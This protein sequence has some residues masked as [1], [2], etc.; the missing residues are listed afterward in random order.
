[1]F[2]C[3]IAFYLNSKWRRR[4]RFVTKK[5]ICTAE[6][7]L[8]SILQIL[9][10]VLSTISVPTSDIYCSLE[11]VLITDDRTKRICADLQHFSC[12]ENANSVRTLV[13]RKQRILCFHGY[14]RELRIKKILS[15][16]LGLHLDI[17][18]WRF[19]IKQN[20]LFL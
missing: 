5:C 20:M 10:L 13:H 7:I 18:K 17:Q 12:L 4:L 9:S 3:S 16:P 15:G 1:L 11:E 2:T 6:S 19:Q 8:T 14:I